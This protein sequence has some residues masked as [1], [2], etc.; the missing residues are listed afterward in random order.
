METAHAEENAQAF[1]SLCVSPKAIPTASFETRRE[2]FF[3]PSIRVWPPS[4]M[5][6]KPHHTDD[7]ERGQARSL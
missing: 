6:R 3:M 5:V 1:A 7:T 2:V 4:G